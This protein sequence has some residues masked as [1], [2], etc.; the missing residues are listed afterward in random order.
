M[1]QPPSAFAQKLLENFKFAGERESLQSVHELITG[2]LMEKLQKSC[3]TEEEARR[4]YHQQCIRSLDWS[5]NDNIVRDPAWLPLFAGSIEEMEH[6][7]RDVLALGVVDA[8]TMRDRIPLDSIPFK[9]AKRRDKDIHILPKDDEVRVAFQAL[10]LFLL[11]PFIPLKYDK[12]KDFLANYPHLKERNGMEQERLRF[13]AN[14]MDLAFHS[15]QPRNNKTFILN[16]IPRIVEGRNA[17]YITG[18]GQTRPTADRVDLFRL[19]G[20]CEKIKR[21]PRK[22]KELLPQDA[23]LDQKNVAN[24]SQ[25]LQ[26]SGLTLLPV[27]EN[28]DGSAAGKVPMLI[29]S[30]EH[31]SL[32]Y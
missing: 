6:H 23:I 22:K 31:F 7:I 19:E 28:N 16:I 1:E 10:F 3:G 27:G 20:Q 14:W 25:L 21:P 29:Y 9:Y 24:I 26:S 11:R 15:I 18:S 5:F 12:L 4:K 2:E 30:G 32:L 17:R 13:T 8:E